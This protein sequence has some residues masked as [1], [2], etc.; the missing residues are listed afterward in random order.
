MP[1][2]TAIRDHLSRDTIRPGRGDCAK[3][4]A[5]TLRSFDP[6]SNVTDVSDSQLEKHFLQST[7]TDLGT[8]IDVKVLNANAD[9]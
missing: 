2:E 9:S 4:S 1:R 6:G 7:S 5:A 3:V 8:I